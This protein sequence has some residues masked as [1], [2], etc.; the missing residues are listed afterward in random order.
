MKPFTARIKII[1]NKSNEVRVPRMLVDFVLQDV[2]TQ[3]TK[4]QY[5]TL[6]EICQSLKRISINR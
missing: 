3:I 2:A 1:I 5:I 6:C 4:Q